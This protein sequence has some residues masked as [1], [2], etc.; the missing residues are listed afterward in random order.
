MPDEFIFFIILIPLLPIKLNI[1]LQNFILFLCFLSQ[2]FIYI[3]SVAEGDDNAPSTRSGL[4]SLYKEANRSGKLLV[5]SRVSNQKVLPWIVSQTGA[6]R[7]YDTVSLSQ[8]L[9]LH[10]HARVSIHIHIFSW[11]RGV[12]T[13]IKGI[14]ITSP[15]ASSLPP[16]TLVAHDADDNQVFPFRYDES[17]ESSQSSIRSKDGPELR[18]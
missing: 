9:S 2:G 11:D 8:K 12:T 18:P 7:C 14:S 16:E 6:I 15:T 1:L 4:C 13:L 17:N 3:S 5:V 10:R